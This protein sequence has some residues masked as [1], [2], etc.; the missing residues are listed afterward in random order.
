M[1]DVWQEVA[2]SLLGIGAG[3]AIVLFV[4]WLSGRMK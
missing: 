2:A 1:S 4:F 3:C